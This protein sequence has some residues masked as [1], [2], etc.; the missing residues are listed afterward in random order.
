LAR[1]AVLQFY[2]GRKF[3]K[4]EENI[5]HSKK[6]QENKEIQDKPRYLTETPCCSATLVP[7]KH[8]QITEWHAGGYGRPIFSQLLLSQ[9]GLFKTLATTI[10]Y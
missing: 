2:R 9:S 10:A 6:N 4:I 1:N 3:K 5:R 8:E 7:P